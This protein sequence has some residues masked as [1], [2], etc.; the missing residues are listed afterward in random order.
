[1]A[2][3]TIQAADAFHTLRANTAWELLDTDEKTAALWRADDYLSAFYQ[4][5]DYSNEDA[6]T[7]LSNNALLD[8]AKIILALE[9]RT[10]QSVTAKSNIT[11]ERKRVEGVIDKEFQY[12]EAPSDPYPQVTAMLRP[13]LKRGRSSP[14]AVLNIER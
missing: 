1:M 12:G 2:I 7:I 13:I 4:F 6:A 14:F 9:F 10:A 3:P 8:T 5:V 11:K